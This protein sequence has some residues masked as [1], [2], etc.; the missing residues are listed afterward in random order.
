VQPSERW[1]RGG[2]FRFVVAASLGLWGAIL[3]V[4]WLLWG[5]F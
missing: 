3:L 5:Y 4:G 2:T 1:S